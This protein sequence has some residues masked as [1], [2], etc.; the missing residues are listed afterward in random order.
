MAHALYLA[1]RVKRSGPCCIC[2]QAQRCRSTL[3][4]PSRHGG[5]SSA[6]SYTTDLQPPRAWVGGRAGRRA[7]GGSWAW[8]WVCLCGCVSLCVFA[9][10]FL[11]LIAVLI[12]PRRH[13]RT[14]LAHKVAS[15]QKTT[16]S[17]FHATSDPCTS[18]RTPGS[19]AGEREHRDNDTFAS[20]PSVGL[21]LDSDGLASELSP[22]SRAHA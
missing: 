12:D 8:L 16:K 3:S 13:G 19:V 15:L 17:R 6:S 21:L 10:L 1:T 2:R 18:L 20:G 4:L 22:W 14:T 11:S 7:G 9:R 5:G